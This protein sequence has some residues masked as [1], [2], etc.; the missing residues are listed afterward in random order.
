MIRMAA[1]DGQPCYMLNSDKV[2]A[3]LTVQGGHLTAEFQGK[4]GPLAPFATLPWWKEP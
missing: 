1:N 2:T 3:W 4:V